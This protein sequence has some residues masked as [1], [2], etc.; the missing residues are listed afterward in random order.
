MSE[1]KTLDDLRGFLANQLERVSSGESTPAAANASA[2]LAGKILG[3][4]KMELE[5][6]KMVGVT[7]HISF[8]KSP[9]KDEP[10]KIED[11]EKNDEQD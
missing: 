9:K 4:V 3:S 7:P 1:L 5:Y 11:K 6:A 10:K 2:N 8:I